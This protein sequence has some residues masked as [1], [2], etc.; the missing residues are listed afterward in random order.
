MC[1]FYSLHL[2][3]NELKIEEDENGNVAYGKRN[4]KLLLLGGLIYIIIYTILQDRRVV[5]KNVRID[6]LI[7]GFIAIFILDVSIMSY[8]YKSFFGRSI[9]YEIGDN[10]SKFNYDEDTHTYSRKQENIRIVKEYIEK[11]N[12]KAIKLYTEKS[13][14]ICLEEYNLENDIIVSLPCGHIFHKEC[15]EGLKDNECPVCRKSYS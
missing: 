9:F 1:I 5:T 12:N 6:G 13:C 11:I 8:T 2:L 7:Y 3:F 10:D 4:C 14:G 15:K